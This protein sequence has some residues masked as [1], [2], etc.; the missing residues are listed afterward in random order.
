[1]PSS[2]VS[3]INYKGGVGKTTLT[4]NIGADLAARGRRV[5]LVDLDPQASLT[6]SFYRPGEWEEQL[7]QSRTVLQWFESYTVT[8]VA[9]PL[10]KYV[11]SPPAVNALVEPNGGRL[12]LL[13]SHLGLIEIDLDLAAALGGARYQKSSPRY[14]PVHRLLADALRDEAFAAHDVVLIDCAPNFNMVTRTAI[15]ASDH[16]LVPARPDYLSTLGIDYLRTRLSRLVTEY[17]EVATKGPVNPEIVG[18]VYTMIQYT[19]AGILKA[20]RASMERMDGIEIPVFRQ[21][22]RENKTAF[23]D[24][25]DRGV[26]AVLAAERTSAVENLRYE[27]QQLTSELVARIRV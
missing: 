16:V 27:L 17:N 25:G 1:M 9:H 6:F 23:T 26:P 8:G 12:D 5:L 2:V 13:A 7:A 11:V 24:A 3:V 4:A 21:T 22:I 15:V 10:R 14:L 18:V 19:G 20:Q